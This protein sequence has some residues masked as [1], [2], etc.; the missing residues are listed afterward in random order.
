LFDPPAGTGTAGTGRIA[1]FDFAED[2]VVAG[3]QLLAVAGEQR[4]KV[5][6][7][8]LADTALAWHNSVIISVARGWL[9]DL[10]AM[11]ISS[12]R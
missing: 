7:L 2:G 5:L 8:G 6:V 3:P 12:R 4:L 1:G 11:V 10:A 9:G